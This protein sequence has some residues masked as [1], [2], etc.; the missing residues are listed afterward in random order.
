[1]S[2][3]EYRYIPMLIRAISVIAC[4]I[5]Q[6]MLTEQRKRHIL[7]LLALQGRIVA[8]DL[9]AA[10]G[11]S[12]DTI[13]RDLRD[14]AAAGLLQ[15]VHGGAL[16]TAPGNAPL[17]VR[18]TQSTAVKRRLGAKAA[19]L[20]RPG[21]V[22]IIDGGTTHL[23]LVRQLASG[24]RATVITHS[25]TIAA[26]LEPHAGLDVILLGGQLYR[27][28]MVAVGAVTA[29][30]YG[31]ISADICFLGVTGLHP[32]EGLTTGNH[33]EAEVKR[34]M[35]TRAADVVVLASPEKFGA[36]SSFR[37]ADLVQAHMLI[38]ADMPGLDD[39]RRAGPDVVLA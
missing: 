35:L 27:Q 6:E 39:Y 8:R 12:E 2:L 15:R 30:A 7:E 38:C 24:L 33:E 1:M 21:Q 4:N 3:H 10:T 25:P 20:V 32:A 9:S 31:R 23:E 16:P 36:A 5:G 11:L 37:I 22:V 29:E 26:A 14:L 18:H 13:R 19:A 28:S 17:A 34:I